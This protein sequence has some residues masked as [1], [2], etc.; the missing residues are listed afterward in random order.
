MEV[1]ADERHITHW[2]NRF[3]WLGDGFGWAETD[4]ENDLAWLI[5]EGNGGSCMSREQRRRL[6]TRRS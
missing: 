1:R 3:E 4:G 5:K 6:E 2:E